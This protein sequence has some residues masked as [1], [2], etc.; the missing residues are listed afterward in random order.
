MPGLVELV[1]ASGDAGAEWQEAKP[2][3]EAFDVLALGGSTDGGD[4]RVRFA[5]G[6]R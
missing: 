6:L 5:A 1:D 2:Y 4:A 3:V